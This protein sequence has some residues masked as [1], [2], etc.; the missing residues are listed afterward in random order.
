M[1]F[2]YRLLFKENSISPSCLQGVQLAEQLVW[3][4]KSSSSK[5]DV[6]LIMGKWELESFQFT[7]WRCNF[8]V[9]VLFIIELLG[10]VELT[11]RIIELWLRLPREQRGSL[12]PSLYGSEAAP[13]L[14]HFHLCPQVQIFPCHQPRCRV[15]RRH[16]SCHPFAPLYSL[17]LKRCE[18]FM[19]WNV[20]E[21]RVVEVVLY[22]VVCLRNYPHVLQ[23]C[24]RINGMRLRPRSVTT[25]GFII[26]NP[27]CLSEYVVCF[28][29]IS[30]TRNKRIEPKPQPCGTSLDSWESL[31]IS[32]ST[33]DTRCV[34]KPFFCP[35]PSSLSQ[36]KYC[37]CR[38]YL[39]TAPHKFPDCL[40]G[41]RSPIIFMIICLHV[42]S[43]AG[44][45]LKLVRLVC[46]TDYKCITGRRR[47]LEIHKGD[48]SCSN[49][50]SNHL[51]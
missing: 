47:T 30:P 14:V 22:G 28:L 16:V 21:F 33:K 3:H 37:S 8:V 13:V 9:C 45:N 35:F 32:N 46:H 44:C 38:R 31:S 34:L 20:R 18:V 6:D 5:A 26:N 15:L 40:A 39:I 43:C 48:V 2:W 4:W 11:S 7:Q 49:I 42:R 36:R 24:P 17:W 25:L 23:L 27:V 1:I 19:E 41:V 51:H 29:I 12:K 10:S 50:V